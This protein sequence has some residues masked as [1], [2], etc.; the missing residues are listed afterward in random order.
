MHMLA[1]K[2]TSTF[3]TFEQPFDK[4]NLGWFLLCM[5]NSGSSSSNPSRIVAALTSGSM[6]A[7][8]PLGGLCADI[9][10]PDIVPM[11]KLLSTHLWANVDSSRT[12]W[13]YDCNHN[14]LCCVTGRK[15]VFLRA[16]ALAS[17]MRVTPIYSASPNHSQLPLRAADISV[18]AVEGSG[19]G[20]VCV[21]VC[22]CVRVVALWGHVCSGRGPNCSIE[23]VFS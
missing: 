18:P 22:V 7:V 14:L 21:C 11:E 20:S 13:H 10:I 6:V 16:P 19:S 2:T 15:T 4:T 3:E 12:N 9:D 17:V 1:T 5:T 8:D 23:L